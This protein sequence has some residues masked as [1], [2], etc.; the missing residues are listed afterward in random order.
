[1]NAS[2]AMN[3]EPRSSVIIHRSSLSST[4]AIIYKIRRR[5]VN[6]FRLIRSQSSFK[7][8]FILGFMLAFETGL[9]I[10][11]QESF[12]FLDSFGGAGM[13]LIGRLFSLFFLGLGS[14]LVI[15]SIVTAYSTMFGSDEI[16]F[17]MVRPFSISQ[18]VLYKF[19]EATGFASW[20]FFFVIVPFVG[21]YAW[22]QKLSPLFALWTLLFSIPFLFLLS[23]LGTLTVMIAVRYIPR[24]RIVK[25]IGF[26][27]IVILA[28]VAWHITGKAIDPLMQQQFNISQLIP[29]M[30]IATHPLNPG[31]WISEGIM[32]L[33]RGQWLRGMI[34][35]CAL[36]S[37][38]LFTT[39]LIEWL[40]KHTF[41]DAWQKII[42]GARTKRNP[43]LLPRLD[44]IQKILPHDITA[45]I[46]KDIRTFF[47]DA[48][49]W[50]QT[51]V[52]FGLLALYFANL[53]TFN[54]NALPDEWRSAIAFLNV[55]AVS[56][57]LSSLG[58]RFI[59]PQLSLEG[60]G[61]W[62]LG[63]SPVTKTKILAAKFILALFSMTTISISLIWL[64]SSMLAT[65]PA[66]RIAAIAIITS[67]ALAVCGVSTGLGAIF[68]DLE[69]RNPAAIVSG[70]GGTLNLVICLGFMLL[71][72]LPFGIIFH[73]GNT[74]I[75]QPA[76]VSTYLKTASLWLITLTIITTITPMWLGL[77]SMQ[78][79][80]Y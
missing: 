4:S 35:F 56:A 12:R 71:S 67:I 76:Q 66:I 49:Q 77:R 1:M 44:L 50:S 60:H 68:L 65:S 11:F 45:I 34:F 51:L 39:M 42:S 36:L 2:P 5:A 13:I 24:K 69:Q 21:A 79:R 48:G 6:N 22:H 31:W 43:I 74:G 9:W 53:R 52:F 62:L 57:V 55:F 40:G 73:L 33:T 15:S 64:S 59:Y 8:M 19:A 30:R 20:A 58:S 32:S 61:F 70:F 29:G 14:M 3:K 16:Q 75:L 17:L 18:I 27:L 63:L 47:R 46:I 80:D 10:L 7:V 54:Y 23:S 38:A 78:N 25:Q 28:V 72:I 26:P 37:T 41:Y